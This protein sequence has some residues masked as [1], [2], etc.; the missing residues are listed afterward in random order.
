[1]SEEYGE[2]EL[3]A[4]HQQVDGWFDE[5]IKSPQYERLTETQKDEA[6]G[7]IRLFVEYSYNYVG[8]AP[9][10]WGR[11]QVIECCV[12]VL[13]RK[14][15]G[16]LTFF[17][18][19]APVLSAFFT[20]LAEKALL[21]NGV[22]LAETVAGLDREIVAASQDTR[23]WGPAKA[24]MMAAQ[25]AGVDVRDQRALNQFMEEYNQR[26][27]PPV[28]ERQPAPVL[29]MASLAPRAPVRH[30][31]PKIGRNDPCGCGSGKKFKKCCGR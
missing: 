3:E 13:P 2:Q 23:D 8:V 20:F 24:F 31:E 9:A 25:Q 28:P 16:E 15:S 1:M 19:V 11:R 10:G 14:V 21:R 22:A 29:P 27:I 7:V 30:S 5:F 6:P 12:E 4:I 26:F 17:Q 18:A